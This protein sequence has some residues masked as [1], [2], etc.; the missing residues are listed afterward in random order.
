MK[1]S[2]WVFQGFGGNE[3]KSV[4][5]QEGNTAKITKHMYK[6]IKM[7]GNTSERSKSCFRMQL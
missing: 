1:F 7:E 5:F 4:A 3:L 2:V 6:T